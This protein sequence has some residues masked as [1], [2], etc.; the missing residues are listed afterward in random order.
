MRKVKEPKNGGMGIRRDVRDQ[1]IAIRVSP[2][3]KEYI[4]S[5]VKDDGFTDFSSW[6]RAVLTTY[7]QGRYGEREQ[8]ESGVEMKNE[9]TKEP[10]K[11]RNLQVGFA[12]TEEEMK[13]LLQCAQRD[14][15]GDDISYWLRICMTATLLAKETLEQVKETQTEQ[16]AK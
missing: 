13:Y 6:I 8:T 15:F 10:R 5:E 14:G 4:L 11:V 3:E 7:L 2:E 16:E 12:V 1:Q 9:P